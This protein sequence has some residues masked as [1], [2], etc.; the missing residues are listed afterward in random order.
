MKCK[1]SSLTVS[2]TVLMISILLSRVDQ[3]YAFFIQWKP[4]AYNTDDQQWA[5]LGFRAIT[6]NSA[7]AEELTSAAC[8]SGHCI[9]SQLSNTVT[10]DWEV[11]DFIQCAV[12]LS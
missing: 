11:S 12:V 9:P 3:L 5:D 4:E 7:E 2:R 1:R 8:D 10:K 6:G